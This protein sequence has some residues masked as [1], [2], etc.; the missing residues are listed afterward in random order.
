MGLG[1]LGNW[2]WHIFS[3]C[4]LLLG[5]DHRGQRSPCPS[6][7][8]IDG[9]HLFLC[10]C[11]KNEVHPR[12]YVKARPSHQA[13]LWGACLSELPHIF[14]LPFWG[15]S[16]APHSTSED[17]G[18]WPW[19][20]SHSLL[21]LKEQMSTWCDDCHPH[22]CCHLHPSD[23]LRD[24][25]LDLLSL[26]YPFLCWTPRKVFSIESKSYPPFSEPPVPH[27]CWKVLT[28]SVYC[29]QAAIVPTS[30]R[31]ICSHRL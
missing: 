14:R 12:A 30:P 10:L 25:L 21:Y 20:Y 1:E 24:P 5:S 7:S 13:D 19:C 15:P 2:P 3:F 18:C 8:N 26:S 11:K 4:I 9:E 16:I 29:H 22:D 31:P 6:Y 17:R 28:L 27:S 23:F